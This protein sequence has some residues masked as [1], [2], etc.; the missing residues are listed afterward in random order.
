MWY[1]LLFPLCLYTFLKLTKSKKR[2]LLI[3][4]GIFMAFSFSM[5][6]MNFVD[7]S[8]FDVSS[9]RK[10]V[11]FRLDS[12][13]FGIL[14][15]MG[16]LMYRK[17][18]DK[19]AAFSAFLGLFSILT[20]LVVHFNQGVV[21]SS[22]LLNPEGFSI[23]H[24]Y[25]EVSIY[26]IEPLPMLF[27][28]PICTKL[29]LKRWNY[30]NRIVVLTSKLSFSIYLTHACF[31]LWYILPALEKSKMIINTPYKTLILYVLYIL[32]TLI[33]SLVLYFSIE[34]PILLWRRKVFLQNK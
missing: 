30:L 28:I 33:F 20:M 16:F 26:Y 31:V 4:I 25:H 17:S 11:L 5:R 22:S 6:L 2:A 24:F 32:L 29:S 15:A 3:S 1:Y 27:F 18:W 9:V 10:V 19:Y 21:T 23:A 34:R 13:M 14:A 7:A 8:I 12:M